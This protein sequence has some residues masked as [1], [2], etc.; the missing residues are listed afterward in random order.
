MRWFKMC[1]WIYKNINNVN[2]TCARCI[3]IV[4]KRRRVASGR[5]YGALPPDFYFCRPDLF[6]APSLYFF[7]EVNITLTVK[8]VIILTVLSPILISNQL[9]MATGRKRF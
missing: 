6:L 3:Q 7:L 8:I 4:Q 5:A 1:L 9:K 2:K